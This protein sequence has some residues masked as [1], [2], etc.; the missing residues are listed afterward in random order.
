MRSVWTD[1]DFSSEEGR[2][3]A[4]FRP[5]KTAAKTLASVAGF[6][7]SVILRSLLLQFQFLEGPLR[8]VFF[9]QV[10]GIP[11]VVTA[12]GPRIV[13]GQTSLPEYF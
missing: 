1:A 4:A 7:K 8:R 6:C 9:F 3:S 2:T 5:H 13:P 11:S 10:I 12:G